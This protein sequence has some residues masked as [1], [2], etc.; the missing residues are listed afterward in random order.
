MLLKDALR[1]KERFTIKAKAGDLLKE[2]E[3]ALS[4]DN[5]YYVTFGMGQRLAWHYQPIKAASEAEAVEIMKKY[6]GMEWAFIYT[7]ED[8]EQSVL[9]S[10]YKRL[11]IIS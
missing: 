4:Y 1:G 5:I 9:L 10:D 11:P 2:I 3:A 7:K 8:F 6:Y